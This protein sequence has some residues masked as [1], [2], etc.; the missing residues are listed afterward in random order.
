[1]A[2][3]N[4]FHEKINN[5]LTMLVRLGYK[6]NIS[7]LTEKIYS[8]MCGTH[9]WPIKNGVN[10]IPYL[11]FAKLTKYLKINIKKVRNVSVY[12]VSRFLTPGNGCYY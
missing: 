6:I 11:I 4:L 12:Y 8:Q 5:F 3:F 7:F 1:M 10:V 2:D 9:V